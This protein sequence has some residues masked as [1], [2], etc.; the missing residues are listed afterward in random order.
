M[1]SIDRQREIFN[2]IQRE[3]TV[4]VNKL[5]RSFGVSTMTIRRDLAEFEKRGVVTTTYGGAYLNKGASIEA[6]FF[7][8]TSQM[9]DK[10]QKIAYEAAKHVD[11]GD[12]IIIDCGTTTLEL[13]KLIPDKKI[14]I[15]TNSWPVS[16]CLKKRPNVT[17]VLAPGEYD[18]ISA[19]T[20]SGQTIT[21]FE[22]FHADKVFMGT[23]GFSIA[24][25]ATVPEILDAEVKRS[26]LN[27]G[28]TKYLLADSTKFNQSYLV[29]HA[30][31][32]DFDYL[33]VDN[34]I[35]EDD[36]RR[37]KEVCRNL[38]ITENNK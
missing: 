5:A 14:K 4:E 27:A 13:V 35:G 8:R 1:N 38:I 34:D 17:L 9:L 6:D 28:A 15:I 25:G 23:H 33:I 32:E 19:G 10:K 2:L 20:F 18:H 37:L 31:L 7:L 11:E 26:L 21:F 22:Q 30:K 29:T 12:T 24:R 36:K 3:K 16:Y